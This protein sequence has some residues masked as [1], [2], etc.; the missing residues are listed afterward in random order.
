MVR[1]AERSLDPGRQLRREGNARTR[2]IVNEVSIIGG[3][4]QGIERHGDDP[5]FDCAPEQ[6]E[7]RG[8]VKH[9]HQEPAPARHAEAEQGIAASRDTF[10][11]GGVAYLLVK[12]PDCNLRAAPLDQVTIDKGRGGVEFGVRNEGGCRPVPTRC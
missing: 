5:G 2:R 4:K 9:R 8:L 3:A 1:P 10:G 11:Q 12:G 6:I 7:E